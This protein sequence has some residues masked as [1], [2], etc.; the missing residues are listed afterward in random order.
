MAKVFPDLEKAQQ[1]KQPPTEGELFLLRYLESNFDDDTE[2]YFQACFDG[3]RPDIVIMK[4]N[5]GLIIVEVKDWNLR[6]YYVDEKN[7]W[8]LLSNNALLK[9]PFAQAFAYKK[10]IFEIHSNGLYERSL[11]SETFY[12]LV[13][14]YVYFHNA[15]KSDLAVFYSGVLGDVQTRIKENTTQLQQKTIRYEDYVKR[16]DYLKSRKRQFERDQTS[17]SVTRENLKRIAFAGQKSNPQF[18]DSVHKE[19]TRLLVPPYHYAN[20]G[21]ELTY[22]KLQ[23]RLAISS[24]GGRAKISGIAGSGKTTVLAKRAVNAHVRHDGT[25]LILTFNLTLRMFIRDKINEVR[26]NFEWRNF[27]ISNYHKFITVILNKYGVLVEGQESDEDWEA[28][29]FSNA[30]LFENLP[31]DEKYQT[32]LIDE[33]QDYKPEWLRILRDNFL[34]ENGEMVLFGDEKQNIYERLIDQ[35]KKPTTI[36]GFGRWEKLSKSFRY[37]QDSHIQHLATTFQHSFLSDKYTLDVDESFQPSLSLIGANV[38]GNYSE[39]NL[40][41]V[42]EIIVKIAKLQMIHPNDITVLSSREETLQLLDF[43][44]RNGN[45]HRERTITSFASKEQ[46]ELIKGKIH[47]AKDLKRNLRSANASKKQGFNLNSGLM[48]LSTIH[49]FKGFESPTVVL[50]VN[51][52]DSPEIIYTGLTR[53]KENII[54]FSTRNCKYSSFF[55]SRLDPVERYFQ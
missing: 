3:D 33:I 46:V 16:D 1:S 4:K 30:Y 48:K 40:R 47:D 27:H 19:L 26:E 17:L 28:K 14:V 6:N 12:G 41:S 10:H 24:S 53:A 13:K 29:Y 38:F 22:T 55:E 36:D 45:S 32:I 11:A 18:D 44:V 25:V 31:I 2:V 43:E 9:S 37:K 39:D 42:A 50:L 15:T 23:T 21:K 5:V 52:S 7:Q 8:K 20:E 34:A 54:I 49:S 51:D 35:D